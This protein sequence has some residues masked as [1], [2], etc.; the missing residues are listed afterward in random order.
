MLAD[1]LGGGLGGARHD[2]HSWT[3]SATRSS[4][5]CRRRC[6]APRRRRSATTSEDF[7]AEDWWFRC[8]FE[9]DPA[10]AAEPAVLELG[11]VA[12]ISEVFLNGVLVLESDSMWREHTVDVTGRL[13]TVN[14]LVIACRALAPLLTK[15]RR[16]AARWRTRVVNNGNLR[17]FRT[18]VFG[19][20]PGF[21]A[22]P[23]A[24]GPWRPVRLRRPTPGGIDHV[25]VTTSVNGDECVVRVRVACHE[26]HPKVTVEAC[27]QR[28]LLREA[29]PGL[30]EAELAVGHAQRWWPHTHGTPALH[31]VV[32]RVGDETVATRRVGFR[33]LEYPQD[34]VQE[35][36]RSRSTVCRCSSA[37]RSGRPRIWSRWPRRSETCGSCWSA[38][39]TRA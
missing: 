4:N 13:R 17:W 31:Q 15:R 30:L 39:A 12:T 26:G 32:V 7:D 25:R 18:M 24:V 35:G 33:T 19:R 2:R 29:G 16:P 1:A 21:A 34:I 20:S 11:G 22:H 10:R 9:L 28:A 23:A 36:L 38:S 8:P 27:G 6:P 14:E 37:V 3:S 5:G